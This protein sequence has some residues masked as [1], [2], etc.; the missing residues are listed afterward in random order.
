M[1]FLKKL[2]A[3]NIKIYEVKIDAFHIAKKDIRKT[4]KLLDFHNDFWIQKMA[5]E[6]WIVKHFKFTKDVMKS[7]NNIAYTN[8]R[9]EAVSNEIRKR[10]GKTCKYEIGEILI[11][12]LYKKDKE[13]KLN[14]N[15]RWK[16]VNNEGYKITI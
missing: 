5:V 1:K 3:N 2:K 6:E 15:I 4:K 13:G 7:R 10:L 16:V 11:C 12:R 14:V 8:I 9:C